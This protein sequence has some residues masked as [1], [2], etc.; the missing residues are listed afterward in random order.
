MGGPKVRYAAMSV[1][2]LLMGASAVV[3][4]AFLVMFIRSVKSGQ[5]DDTWSPSRR[6]LMDDDRPREKYV[7]QEG[8]KEHEQD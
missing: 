2:F 4:L 7:K 5:F 1:V 6:M 8:T 3:A